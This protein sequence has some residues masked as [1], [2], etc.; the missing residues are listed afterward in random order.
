MALNDMQKVYF[1]TVGMHCTL[2]F[3]VPPSRTGEYQT[4]GPIA[5]WAQ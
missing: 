4:S 3:N 5:R 1:Q 2:N